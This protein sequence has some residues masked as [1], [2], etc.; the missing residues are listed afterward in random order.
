MVH[1]LLHSNKHPVLDA[2]PVVSMMITS[3]AL[4]ASFNK[5]NHSDSP[6]ARL[7]VVGRR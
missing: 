6:L 7:Y 5:A 2:Y 4:A 3:A 1:H